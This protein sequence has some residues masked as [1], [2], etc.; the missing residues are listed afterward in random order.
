MRLLIFDADYIVENNKPTIRLFCKDKDGKSVVVLD[1]SFYSYFYV[2]PKKDLEKLKEK[3][4]QWSELY[5]W[6]IV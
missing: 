5:N 2:K 3:M 4:N 6:V 1:R